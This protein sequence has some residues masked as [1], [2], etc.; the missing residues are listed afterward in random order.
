MTEPIAVLLSGGVDSAVAAARLVRSG[1]DVRAYFLA[2]TAHDGEPRQGA[3]CSPDD[4][5]DARAVARALG[6]PFT[7]I[8]LE[9]AFREIVLEPYLAEYAA[10]RTPNP[11]TRCNPAIK[12]GRFAEL[13]QASSGITRV[14]SGHH[15]QLS[16]DEASGSWALRRGADRAKDQSY[17]LFGLDQR[18]LARAVFPVGNSPKAEVREEAQRL[19]LPV[20][21]KTESQEVCFVHPRRRGEFIAERTGAEPGEIV[22][23]EGKVLGRHRGLPYYTVGQRKGL[24]IAAPEPLFVIALD[25][26]CNRVVVGPSAALEVDGFTLQEYNP[27]AAPMPDP[28]GLRAMVQVRYRAEPVACTVRGGPDHTVAVRFDTPHGPVAPGQAAV[29]YDGEVVLGGGW[30]ADEVRA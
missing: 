6:I 15:A 20:A 22:D 3:C 26:A 10:G 4:A 28:E 24:G 12:F 23:R 25:A 2:L 9:R 13:V 18:Q 16:R 29:I 27:V 1:A 21:E 5:A 11:C 19:G 14:A 30:I 8:N 17:F 7:V